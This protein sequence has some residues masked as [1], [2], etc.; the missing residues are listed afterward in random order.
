MG[1]GEEHDSTAIFTFKVVPLLSI[2]QGVDKP[3]R[4]IKNARVLL[5]LEVGKFRGRAVVDKIIDK[6]RKFNSI[7]RVETNGG[8]EFLRQWTLDTDISIPIRKHHTGPAKGHRINGVA[9]LFIE[10]ENGAWVIPCDELGMVPHAVQVWID[11]CLNYRPPPAHTGDALMASYLARAQARELDFG[12]EDDGSSIS[13][14]I[15]AR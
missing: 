12:G 14:A 3:P 7:V 15:G 13:A 8:Q 2:P 5:D 4:V 10:L 9:G 1:Q 6:V 11:E